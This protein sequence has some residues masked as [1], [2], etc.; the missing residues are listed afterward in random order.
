MCQRCFQ[1]SNH[2]WHALFGM[3]LSS[4]SDSVFISSIVA[5]RRLSWVSS[6]LATGKSHLGLN[7]MNTVAEAWLRYCFWPKNYEQALTSEQVKIQ[8]FWNKL[9]C[10]TLQTKNIRNI[11]KNFLICDIQIDFWKWTLCNCT[12]WIVI[13][14][15]TARG[16]YALQRILFTIWIICNI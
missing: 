5:K 14:R 2:I 10:H 15:L 9:R 8:Q 13:R 1:S 11:C 16:A 4:L 6:I 12:I 7:L 3:S